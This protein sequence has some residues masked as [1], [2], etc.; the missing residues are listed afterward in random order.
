MSSLSPPFA[1][2]ALAVAF[3]AGAVGCG[4]S[5][6]SGEAAPACE[7]CG[8]TNFTCTAPE[9]EGAVLQIDDQK[10]SGCVG[11]MTYQP[12][13]PYEIDCE[14]KRICSQGTCFDASIAPGEITWST[15]TCT[16]S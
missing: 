7:I 3:T 4:D 6:T 14:L 12:G 5:S 10:P 1:F 15:G 8:H 11:H 13:V 16:A 9:R 2:W